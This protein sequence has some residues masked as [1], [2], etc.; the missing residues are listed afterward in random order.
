M[1]HRCACVARRRCILSTLSIGNR[2]LV[3]ELRTRHGPE[4]ET[5]RE[6]VQGTGGNS[7]V[8][9]SPTGTRVKAL[10]PLIDDLRS[11]T[12]NEQ[13]RL[14]EDLPLSE[15]FETVSELLSQKDV[16]A[17]T[18][19]TFIKAN[20]PPPEK[21]TPHGYTLAQKS[22]LSNALRIIMLQWTSYGFNDNAK[23]YQILKIYSARHFVTRGD[24]AFCLS[25]L[26]KYAY[27]GASADGIESFNTA[28]S[29]RI[30]NATRMR[31]LCKSWR[32]F[33]LHDLKD[34]KSDETSREIQ[35]WRELRDGHISASNLN[36][37]DYAHRFLA[38]APAWGNYERTDVEHQIA[39]ASILTLVA[40]YKNLEAPL[41]QFRDVGKKVQDET[42]QIDFHA[43]GTGKDRP[44]IP[45]WH[46]GP[47]QSSYWTPEIGHLSVSEAS[48]LYLVASAAKNAEMNLTL[49][50]LTLAQMSLPSTEV[51]K[52]AAIYQGFKSSLP[53]LFRKFEDFQYERSTYDE[54]IFRR[55]PLRAYL[56]KAVELKDVKAI[57]YA[58][59]V[60]AEITD[61]PPG[62]ALTLVKSSL[63]MGRPEKA[64]FYW[65]TVAQDIKLKNQAWQIWL[66]YAFENGDLIAYESAWAK[67][68]SNGVSRT[69]KMWHKRL[70][71]HHQNGLPLV[72]WELFCLLVRSSGKN[73]EMKG[74]YRPFILLSELDVNIFHMMIKAYL[75]QK[76]S[77][78]MAMQKATDTLRLLKRQKG[79]LP[80]RETY[81]LFVKNSLDNGDR[82]SAMRWFAEGRA[83]SAGFLLSDYAQ[84]FEYDLVKHDSD[85]SLTLSDPSG[86]IRHAFDAIT[87]NMRLIRGSR[88]YI[89]PAHQPPDMSSPSIGKNPVRMHLEDDVELHLPDQVDEGSRLY[90]IKEVQTRYTDLM[91]IL[92]EGFA[93]KPPGRPKTARLRLLLLL[94]DHC[95][96]SSIPTS[97]EMDVLLRS[98]INS[99]HFELQEKLMRGAM[100]NNYNANDPVSFHSYRFLRRF[101]PRW[102]AHRISLIYPNISRKCLSQLRWNG[103]EGVDDTAL[104]MA[105][106][107]SEEDRNRI[108]AEVR[109]WRSQAALKRAEAAEKKKARKKEIEGRERLS[110]EQNH[111]FQEMIQPLELLAQQ[112][113]GEI[114]AKEIRRKELL[115]EIENARG[116]RDLQRRAIFRMLQSTRK[117]HVNRN[118]PRLFRS[119]LRRR[120]RS[121]VRTPSNNSAFRM[122]R[123][124]LP[125]VREALST[126]D[127]HFRRGKDER[128]SEN[129]GRDDQ[130]K[131]S[132]HHVFKEPQNT[133][134]TLKDLAL[135]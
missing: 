75:D 99:L 81:M 90:Q 120:V 125:K 40:L 37:T 13:H 72:A 20:A 36:S 51:R 24:W 101:G 6:V 129:L 108:L 118:S 113:T 30:S 9:G 42:T 12:A 66:D 130:V 16:S 106:V 44:R 78:V 47:G 46:L 48:L 43:E 8:Y 38:A 97:T 35:L 85:S 116:V 127:V 89:S 91:Q 112:Q 124:P 34:I 15:F 107:S 126:T 117:S 5:A 1:L 27:E 45:N 60:A 4:T 115:T 26:A 86:N 132:Q 31:V 67:L 22:L 63:Q 77:K 96:M 10:S 70:L 109:T 69:L 64:L 135:S 114:D 88:L 123:R 79:V 14:V 111:S 33:L 2:S 94:W 122:N 103:F 95:L 28:L 98:V 82:E 53:D 83:I 7:D 29:Q 52:I 73:E 61:I 100:F 62:D 93:E 119:I 68:V 50:K 55:Y 32:L 23:R 58:G 57:D 105:G 110:L 56:Q 128:P 3:A 41:H 21:R 17:M 25:L 39:Y 54:G 92:A 76:T 71:L 19:F 59:S 131:A 11:K 18:L 121:R 104:I 49:L 65:N 133:F 87:V 74:S 80:N 134:K 84:L 102:F